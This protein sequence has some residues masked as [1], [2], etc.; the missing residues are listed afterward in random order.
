M[1]AFLKYGN[2][3]NLKFEIMNNNLHFSNVFATSLEINNFN[4]LRLLNCIW[5]FSIS[6][7][8]TSTEYSYTDLIYVSRNKSP[9]NIQQS[10]LFG[11]SR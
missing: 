8:A 2:L 6:R 1:I 5:S 10:I 7:V 4:R 3:F 11:E 9:I